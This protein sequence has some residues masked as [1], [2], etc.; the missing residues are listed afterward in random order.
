MTEGHQFLLKELG[1][2]PRIGWHI[3]PFG[4]SS[5][6][7]SFF[8]QMGFDAFI[9]NRLDYED[10]EKRL[11]DKTMQFIWQGSNSRSSTDDIFS[12][13]LL[14]HYSAPH[15]FCFDVS[16]DDPVLTP[17][18]VAERARAFQLYALDH[19]S[20]YQ[21]KHILVTMGDD[22]QYEKASKNFANMDI[23]ID[24]FNEH[25]ELGMDV[26]YSTPSLYIDKVHRDSANITWTTKTDDFFPYA[27]GP[28]SYWTGY[29]TS[30]PALKKYVRDSS[31][32]LTAVEQLAATVTQFSANMSRESLMDSLSPAQQAISV[33]QHHD[34]VS[35]TEKQHV[36]NDYA[37][38]LA[39]GNDKAE[40]V[41]H[42]TL[43]HL[44]TGES[45]SQFNSC[46]LL[47]ESRC[48][49][50]SVLM[51]EKI[52]AVTVYNPSSQNRF[53]IARIPIPRKDVAVLNSKFEYIYSEV[54]ST[55]DADPT[56]LSASA[57]AYTLV[58]EYDTVDSLGFDTFFIQ[59]APADVK[60]QAVLLS[61]DDADRSRD[62]TIKSAGASLTFA[63]GNGLLKAATSSAGGS[64]KLS[65]NLFVFQSNKGD[66][67]DGQA[68]GAYI[69][70]PE[71][72]STAVPASV[73]SLKI[74]R[75]RIFSQAIQHFTF[76]SQVMHTVSWRV[77]NKSK[78]AEAF[79][80]EY[81][82]RS[83]KIF[84]DQGAELISRFSS[85]LKTRGE[86]FTDANGLEMQRR[87]RNQRPSWK[88]TVTEPVASNYYPINSAIY[89]QDDQHRLSVLVD[90]AQG[91]SS[92]LD[93]SVEVML[94]RRMVHDDGRGVGE[95]LN[96]PGEDGTGLI[97]RG[98]HVVVFSDRQ[99]SGDWQRQL[100]HA[101]HHAPILSF[102]EASERWVSKALLNH[103]PVQ[104]ELPANVKLLTLKP[105]SDG[106][107]LI[108]LQHIYGIDESSTYSKA[109]QVDL[110][111][112]F[113]DLSVQLVEELNLSANQRISSV[114]K[115]QWNYHNGHETVDQQE[116]KGLR[117]SLNPLEIR[118]FRVVLKRSAGHPHLRAGKQ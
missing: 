3:D 25:P 24:Y 115:L 114:Q 85:N 10:K 40:E 8:A 45:G 88:T 33:L 118:T 92:L 28:H 95:P 68:S 14:E 65:H 90:R 83:P 17:A 61:V 63:A 101:V 79:E 38:R 1:V 19:G 111:S 47:N 69:F 89:I 52:V 53:G 93:G 91:G 36:A 107:T 62:Q 41:F 97:V 86:F 37:E 46:P 75:G 78:M 43:A 74:I 21:T 27:D 66:N 82:I 35:G 15:G 105:M 116:E 4:H 58:F 30:R 6:Q 60:H 100:E 70:R 50:V 81:T 16:C 106:S 80:M 23:L 104:V 13:A 73:I 54:Y 55:H 22:F 64:V 56:P 87:I 72:N 71:T 113:K 94:H 103:S 77:Y 67:I 76:T 98:T 112:L 109:V 99:R 49:A 29:F 96:E 5:T 9:I 20:H 11:A 84:D 32:L 39:V 34:G 12:H 59:P 2:K 57:L 110:T 117:I 51:E 44:V 26:F 42:A 7:A 18:N 102:A 48:E 108:R 31:N